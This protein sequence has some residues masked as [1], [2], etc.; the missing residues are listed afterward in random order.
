M[1]SDNVP[2]LLMLG[3]CLYVGSLMLAGGVAKLRDLRGAWVG[4]LE[5][6]II[7]PFL[8]RPL[9][10]SLAFAEVGVGSAVMLGVPIAT[11]IAVF[12]FSIVT[13]AASSALARGLKIDCHCGAG[14]EALTAHTLGRN[15]VLIISLLA[16]MLGSAHASPFT[17]RVLDLDVGGGLSLGLSAA[18]ALLLMV[19]LR[20]WSETT[21][22]TEEWRIAAR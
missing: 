12:F 15:T 9:A 21:K 3:V 14:D 4:V 20:A 5:Y 10:A 1:L 22:A 17:P 6:R 16:V 11:P 7:P 2:R 19:G 13:A 8:A 18:V